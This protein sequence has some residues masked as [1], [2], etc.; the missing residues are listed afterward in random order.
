VPREFGLAR[1]TVGK[2]LKHPMPPGYMR[3]ISAKRP[4][5]GS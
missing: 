4:K 5:L 2:M 1:K 3:Q